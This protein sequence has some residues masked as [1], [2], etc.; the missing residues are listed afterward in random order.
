MGGSGSSSGS[1]PLGGLLERALGWL[2]AWLGFALIILAGIAVAVLGIVTNTKVAGFVAFGVAAVASAILAWWSGGKSE[3][4]A[5][6]F[7][8]SFGG[9]VSRIDGWVWLVIFGLFVVASIIAIV[10]T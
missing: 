3:P 10:T 6:P 2:P 7:D 5:N 4:R 1:S 9:V 8:R